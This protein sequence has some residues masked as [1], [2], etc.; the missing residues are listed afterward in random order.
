MQQKALVFS[1]FVVLLMV[2]IAPTLVVGH[3]MML[4]PPQRSS[5]FR[6]GFKVPPNYNDNGLNCGGFG[7]I[8][9]LTGLIVSIFLNDFKISLID[10]MWILRFL[11]SCF[12]LGSV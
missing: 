2:A 11:P 6:F 1:V 3:G 7:V 8:N 4:S 5:M 10:R 12:L 9:H